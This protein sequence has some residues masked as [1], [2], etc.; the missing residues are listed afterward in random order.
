MGITTRR[1]LRREIAQLEDLLGFEV[2]WRTELQV[3]N[4]KLA[5][6]APAGDER[7][8]PGSSPARA[9]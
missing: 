8:T 2:R 6:L 7:A 3:E 9:R 4:R 5:E 1:Q